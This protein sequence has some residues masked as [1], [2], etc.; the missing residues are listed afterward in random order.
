M[1]A[2]QH[3][4]LGATGE[5]AAHVPDG[6]HLKQSSAFVLLLSLSLCYRGVGLH[7][8]R[9]HVAAVAADSVGKV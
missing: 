2:D 1:V 4:V 9:H 5:L 7:R 6:R 8:Q 3:K